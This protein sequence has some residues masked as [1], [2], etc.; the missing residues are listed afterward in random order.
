MATCAIS[1]TCW[2]QMPARCCCACASACGRA[3]SLADWLRRKSTRS[4]W[5]AQCCS[6]FVRCSPLSCCWLCALARSLSADLRAL[7]CLPPSCGWL[8]GAGSLAQPAGRA[9]RGQSNC[10]GAEASDGADVVRPVRARCS[11]GRS[12]AR[13]YGA[14]PSQQRA[15][16]RREERARSRARTAGRS[17]RESA[18]R[19]RA[20]PSPSW[21]G[22]AMGTAAAELGIRRAAATDNNAAAQSN[23]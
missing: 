7:A 20:Q 9:R 8:A 19:K 12:L 10:S 22:V 6:V 23:S 11:L 18:H 13:K 17:S 14:R 2:L 5:H 16:E 21:R 1:G 4:A 3:R 15:S